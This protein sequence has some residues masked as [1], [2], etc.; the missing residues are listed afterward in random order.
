MKITFVCTGNTC[1]SPMAEGIARALAPGF[2]V[3]SR[4]IF[5]TPGTSTNEHTSKLLKAKLDIELNHQAKQIS[6]EDCISSDLVLT[7]TQAQAD[8]IRNLGECTEVY[9]LSEYAGEEGEVP[10]PFGGSLFEYEQTFEHLDY[11]IRKVL[12]RIE[13]E[14]DEE[15]FS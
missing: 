7:M 8:F 2:E 6:D 1:R 5:V 3:E 4:G 9:T 11:L 15:D 10:D 12:K 14:F 13:S